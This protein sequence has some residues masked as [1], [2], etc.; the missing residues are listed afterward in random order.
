MGCLA[1]QRLSGRLQLGWCGRNG[2][3]GRSKG[4]NVCRVYDA[5]AIAAY[6]LPPAPSRHDLCKDVPKE[7]RQTDIERWSIESDTP[8]RRLRH[9]E[10][11]MQLS[12]TPPYWARP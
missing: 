7:I 11:T 8:L 3:L 2:L 5:V 4:A 10:P 12:E 6:A 1:S 9:L